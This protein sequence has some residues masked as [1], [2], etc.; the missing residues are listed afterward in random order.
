MSPRSTTC[1]L[2]DTDHYFTDSS[3]NNNEH[4]INKKKRNKTDMEIT[5]VSIPLPPQQL[6]LP[7]LKKRKLN[8]QD[9]HNDD[10]YN[11]NTN[12]QPTTPV[13]PNI[14][15]LIDANT[16]YS[17]KNNE[18][19][20]L[21]QIITS[22]TSTT[23]AIGKLNNMPQSLSQNQNNNIINK[24]NT[25]MNEKHL[26][27]TNICSHF[28]INNYYWKDVFEEKVPL[29]F[30]T[31]VIKGYFHGGNKQELKNT[32][33]YILNLKNIVMNDELNLELTTKVSGTDLTKTVKTNGNLWH[34]LNTGKIYRYLK[35]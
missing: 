23:S 35:T 10:N 12:S 26:L 1:S 14:E 32:L 33:K 6:G 2:F 22:T 7:P 27:L 20:S 18:I 5:D 28:P 4:T 8:D 25:V 34:A 11:D 19:N 9:E 29:P 24:N 30:K 21:S 31:F 13:L 15:I 3:N 16:H 17:T